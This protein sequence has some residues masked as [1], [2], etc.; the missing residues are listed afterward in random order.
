MLENMTDFDESDDFSLI[1]QTLQG[2]VRSFSNIVRKYQDRIYTLVVQS[3]KH[4]EDAKDIAQNTFLNAFS[5]LKKFRRDS[6]FSTW[7]HR[8]AIN[9]IKNYWRQNRKRMIVTESDLKSFSEEYRDRF[10]ELPDREQDE[11]LEESKRLANEI[12]SFLPLEQRQIFILYYVIGYSCQEIA[13][14]FKTSTSNVKI[15]L[16]RGRNYL[17]SKFGNLFSK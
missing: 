11:H 9:Q 15:Q 2:N 1:D 8:I 10:R 14:I 4:Q 17:Y 13:T 5:S 7:L 6:S 16:Y 12:I 3:I